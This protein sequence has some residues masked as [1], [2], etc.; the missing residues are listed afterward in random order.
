[1]TAASESIIAEVNRSFEFYRNT[2]VYEDISEVILCGGCVLIK[3]FPN[4]FTE[5][6]HI[7]TR[8]IEPFRNIKVPKK[9][10][11]AYMEEM[12]PIA[13]VATGLALRRPGDR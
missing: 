13:A 6:L 4:L 7:E 1:M 10:N 2:A 3:D 9:F 12:A 8:V 5:R 11:I